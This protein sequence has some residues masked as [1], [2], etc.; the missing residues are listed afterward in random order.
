MRILGLD[1]S[2]TTRDGMIA[3]GA[4]GMYDAEAL[5]IPLDSSLEGPLLEATVLH[6]I[7][8]A[9]SD[10]LHLGLTEAQVMGLEAGLY[11]TLTDAGVKLAA[12]TK[13]LG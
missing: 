11:A 9:L 1:Y 7:I 13:E 10:R 4:Y 12:I 6:E 2:L 8:E 3:L 5:T